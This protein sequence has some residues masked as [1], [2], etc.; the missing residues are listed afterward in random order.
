LKEFLKPYRKEY[1]DHPDEH[2]YISREEYER[3]WE[4]YYYE[5]IGRGFMKRYGKEATAK[6]EK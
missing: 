6:G 2:K 5:T 1:E 4:S 3:Q